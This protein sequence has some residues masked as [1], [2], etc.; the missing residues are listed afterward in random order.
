MRGRPSGPP[1]HSP[2]RYAS[3]TP[4]ER[5]PNKVSRKITSTSCRT[6]RAGKMK[7][8]SSAGRRRIVESSGSIIDEFARDG[9]CGVDDW[10]LLAQ[11]V[12]A[13]RGCDS[14]YTGDRDVW[15]VDSSRPGWRRLIRVHQ[16]SAAL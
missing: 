13:G 5:N 16:L 7:G 15:P 14:A 12:D 1:S 11:S 9:V 6:Q 3:F 8:L 10:R 4:I 2:F